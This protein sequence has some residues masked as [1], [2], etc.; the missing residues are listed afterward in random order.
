MY[1]RFSKQDQLLADKSK[2]K[3]SSK[4]AVRMGSMFGE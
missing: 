1:F 3:C 2:Y 4:T